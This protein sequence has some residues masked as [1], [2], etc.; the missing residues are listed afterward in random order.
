MDNEEA[1][2]DSE[3]VKHVTN[4]LIV[5]KTRKVVGQKYPIV[6]GFSVLH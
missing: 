5:K 3:F 6:Y 4:M 2:V 1:L